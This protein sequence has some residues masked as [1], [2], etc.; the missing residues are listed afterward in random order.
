MA[1]GEAPLVPVPG[2]L[3]PAERG[4]FVVNATEARW[5]EWGNFGVYCP[6]EGKLPLLQLG[7]NLS[8]LE[9]GQSLGR[10]HREPGHEEDFLVLD[11]ERVL[12]VE[13]EERPLA[14][15]DFVHCP[16]G[17]GHM[18]VGA[19]DGPAVVLAVG[20]RGD[21]RGVERGVTYPVSERA[22]RRGV[23]IERETDDSLEAYADLPRA[24][25][26]VRYN[27]WLH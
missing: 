2:G 25:K 15:W 24:R 27:G 13:E 14:R 9:P 3:I 10:Y 11:G 16:P 19:G 21:G 22:A 5:K 1:A 7:I 17:V 6:F 20:T 4:W 12:I 18:I 23:S 8:V 26:S